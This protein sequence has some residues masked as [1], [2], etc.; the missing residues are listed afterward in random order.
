MKPKP[1]F[2]NYKFKIIFKN[3][4][5]I[6]N[7]KKTR[8]GVTENKDLSFKNQNPVLDSQLVPLLSDSKNVLVLFFR[9]GGSSEK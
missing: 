2:S 7:L 4:K 6:I 8:T 3:K 9:I 1:R 5:Q